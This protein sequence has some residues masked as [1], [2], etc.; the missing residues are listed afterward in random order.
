VFGQDAQQRAKFQPPLIG[1]QAVPKFVWI[2][3][4]KFRNFKW[5]KSGL[6]EIRRGF[7]LLDRSEDVV[8]FDDAQE[9]GGI[10]L[11]SADGSI[12]TVAIDQLLDHPFDSFCSQFRSHVTVKRTWRSTLLHVTCKQQI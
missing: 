2:F 8:T 9:D 11:I 10:R 6:L 5:K 1:W 12:R 4:M 3:L 7:E